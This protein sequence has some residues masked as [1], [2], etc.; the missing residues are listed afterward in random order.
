MGGSDS[1]FV[2]IVRSRE[3]LR[4]RAEAGSF[5][6]ASDGERRISE[7]LIF[8]AQLASIAPDRRP[9]CAVV[10][11]GG[12]VTG[13]I[14]G[15]QQR[16]GPFV[17]GV[18]TL[19]LELSYVG[20][21]EALRAAI[22]GLLRTRGVR[23]V[24][25]ERLAGSEEGLSAE[26]V[27]RDGFLDVQPVSPKKHYGVLV[28]QL[29]GSGSVAEADASYCGFVPTGSFEHALWHLAE[30]SKGV[31]YGRSMALISLAESPF[32][33]GIRSPQGGWRE[34][35]GGWFEGDTLMVVFQSLSRELPRNMAQDLARRGISRILFLNGVPDSMRPIAYEEPVEVLEIREGQ[36]RTRGSW[37]RA[38]IRPHVIRLGDRSV[39]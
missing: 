14:C 25:V 27:S 22:H 18:V 15:F 31:E 11:E 24:R 5:F 39:N 36:G 28:E 26:P 34:L 6:D 16:F 32:L 35:V 12:Q 9:C 19:D 38:G 20:S 3:E 7:T 10:T 29:S 2:Q 21:A 30:K 33:A 23:R 1:F 13:L 4:A 37:S 17:S 8:E